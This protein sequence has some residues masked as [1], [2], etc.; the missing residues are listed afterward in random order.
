MY[1]HRRK[2][3][4]QRSFKPVTLELA[5]LLPGDRGLRF[6]GEDNVWYEIGIET[7]EEMKLLLSRIHQLHNALEFED[8]KTD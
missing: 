7:E 5:H 2:H 6:R 1:L 8:G 3:A 4:S